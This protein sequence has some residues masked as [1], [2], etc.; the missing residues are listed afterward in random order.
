MMLGDQTES[1]LGWTV[2]DAEQFANHMLT[3]ENLQQRFGRELMVWSW[4]LAREY[5]ERDL[6]AHSPKIVEQW[7][8]PEYK[9][10]MIFLVATGIL[11]GVAACDGL[12]GAE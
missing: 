10:F 12:D 9:N 2:M 7:Q 3:R 5:V 6:D 1:F 4:D 11:I 8:A